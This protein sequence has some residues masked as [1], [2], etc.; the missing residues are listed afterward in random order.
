MGELP[1]KISRRPVYLLSFTIYVVASIGLALQHSYAALLVLRMLQS[2]G[3]SATRLN[4]PVLPYLAPKIVETKRRVD[5]LG[6]SS[7]TLKQKISATVPN[8][9][10]AIRLIFEKETSLILLAVYYIIQGSLPG[11]LLSKYG[12]NTTAIGLPYLLI[13][14]GIIRRGVASGMP[15]FPVF[16][17]SPRCK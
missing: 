7:R 4:E 13:S 17:E 8:P 9:F 14:L 5:A 1:D 6:E 12:F 11:L 2:L 16:L 10:K 3:A 15:Y